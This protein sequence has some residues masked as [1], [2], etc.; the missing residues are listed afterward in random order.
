MHYPVYISFK[1]MPAFG[2]EGINFILFLV[3][4][5]YYPFPIVSGLMNIRCIFL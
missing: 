3:I 4:H 5:F 2:T 1:S